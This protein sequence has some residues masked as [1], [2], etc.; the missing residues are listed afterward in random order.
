VRDAPTSPIA[1][2]KQ[3]AAAGR[4]FCAASHFNRNRVAD[5]RKFQHLGHVTDRDN[6]QPSLHVVRISGRFFFVIC[7]VSH[8]LDTHR[9]RP[10]SSFSSSRRFSHR[11]ARN[12]TSPVM[13]MSLRTGIPVSTDTIEVTHRQ[14]ALARLWASPRR[15][16]GRGYPCVELEWCHAILRANGAH[17]G[18]PPLDRLLHTI[19][20]LTG[21]LHPPFY[22]AVSAPRY[23]SK[24]TPTLDSTPTGDNANL[25]RSSARPYLKR[26]R[27]SMSLGFPRHLRTFFSLLC[28]TIWVTLYGPA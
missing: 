1:R 6:L 16:R 15:A 20:Q 17:V 18:R 21:C 10:P 11:I 7:R 19:A 5:Q 13:A 23:A 12:D 4:F 26:L 27:P 25:I 2:R 3:Q 9:A 14:T 28:G 8:C 24:F 22:R